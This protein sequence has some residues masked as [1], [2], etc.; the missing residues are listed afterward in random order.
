MTGDLKNY[1]SSLIIRQ[2]VLCRQLVI[3]VECEILMHREQTSEINSV[4]LL[5]EFETFFWLLKVGCVLDEAIS[6]SNIRFKTELDVLP[7]T[8]RS[9]ETIS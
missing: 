9:I 7:N 6:I 1:R 8:S 2:P 5:G 4:V 3:T